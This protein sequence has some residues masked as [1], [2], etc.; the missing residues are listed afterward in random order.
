VV[1]DAGHIELVA[2]LR[3]HTVEPAGDRVRLIGDQ[4]HDQD[5]AKVQVLRIEADQVIAATGFRPDHSIAAELRLG[6]EPAL[7]SAAALGPL[8]DPNVHTCGTVPAHGVAELAHPEAGYVIVGMKSYGRA[9]TFLLAAGYQQVRSVVAALAGDRAG[10][11]PH[12]QG[13]PAVAMCATNRDLLAHGRRR[14]RQPAA[15]IT[16]PP[17]PVAAVA[18]SATD[19]SAATCC[20]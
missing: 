16:G 8:I 20:P 14:Q 19:W 10:A 5:L 2:G 1:A 18:S 12:D 9:P 3:I 6:L 17:T 13:P 15:S 4:L 7:E 11:T